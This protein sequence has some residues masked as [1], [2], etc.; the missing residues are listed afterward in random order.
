MM[1]MIVFET[2]AYDMRYSL[3]NNFHTRVHPG[4]GIFL[5]LFY[6][7]QCVLFTTLQISH[8]ETYLS[9]SCL[10]YALVTIITI[11]Q[12]P[13]HSFFSNS[14]LIF[15]HL[16]ALYLNFIFLL[17]IWIDSATA[18]IVLSFIMQPFI[19][20]LSMEMNKFL[21]N[22]KC[23][24]RSAKYAKVIE[25]EHYLR[26]GLLKHST[27]PKILQLFNKNVQYNMRFNNDKLIRVLQAYYCLEAL[28]DPELAYIKIG[29]CEFSGFNFL[30]NYQV[31]KCKEILGFLNRELSEG[32]KLFLFHNNFD[33]TKKIDFEI[34]LSLLSLFSKILNYPQDIHIIKS[35]LINNYQMIKTTKRKYKKL[36][37]EVPD[38]IVL[39]DIYS[40]FLFNILH[41]EDEGIEF[42]Q[43]RNRLLTELGGSKPKESM[44]KKDY[45]VLITSGSKGISG[46][47]VYA[48]DKMLEILGHNS[49]SIKECYLS[50]FIPMPFDY[51]H[52]NL[53]YNFPHQ[54]IS[55]K[56]IC[57]TFNFISVNEFLI[58]CEFETECIIYGEKPYFLSTFEM[59]NIKTRSVVL[60][61]STGFIMS[62][63]ENFLSM[64]SIVS[65]KEKN[66]EDI[67]H[68]P[69]FL[70]KPI[71]TPIKVKNN[72]LIG[73]INLIKL[74]NNT[75]FVVYFS[76]N[77][78]ELKNMMYKKSYTIR[79]PPMH[80]LSNQQ[81]LLTKKTTT[82]GFRSKTTYFEESKIE[83]KFKVS[84]TQSNS[85]V[86][87][88]V[89]IHK[90]ILALN[91]S[92]KSFK[93]MLYILCI[94]ILVV[95]TVTSIETYIMYS[96]GESLASL[97]HLKRFGELNYQLTKLAVIVRS[98]DLS[99]KN[100]ID[101]WYTSADL[102]ATVNDTTTIYKYFIDDQKSLKVCNSLKSESFIK[103]K[104]FTYFITNGDIYYS[105]ITNKTL[106]IQLS[107]L[108]NLI[109]TLLQTA[110][111]FASDSSG[112]SLR[113]E[114]SFLLIYNIMGSINKSLNSV[115]ELLNLCSKE[116]GF[117]LTFIE[118]Y[119]LIGG[120]GILGGLFVV[121]AVFVVYSEKH[122]RFLWDYLQD[123]VD[124][125]YSEIRNNVSERLSTVHLKDFSEE[126]ESKP[127]RIS[128]NNK[129]VTHSLRHLIRF[130]L[131]FALCI[132]I[133]V[134]QSKYFIEEIRVGLEYRPY[135]IA[136]FA[137]MKTSI[138]RIIF[139]TNEYAIR[140]SEYRLE[141]YYDFM[142]FDQLGKN[143][144]S[145]IEK[146]K[147]I[148]SI[149]RESNAKAL[150]TKAAED[151]LYNKY[152]G[153]TFSLHY[154]LHSATN[155]ISSESSLLRSTNFNLSSE[156]SAFNDF[157]N[158]LI[159]ATQIFTEMLDKTSYDIIISLLQ[160]LIYFT[161]SSNFFL[162]L[163]F[164]G[165]YLPYLKRET[166]ILIFLRKFS[167]F[168]PSENRKKMHDQ[169]QIKKN[170]TK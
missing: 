147:S 153:S 15:I 136:S 39:L 68:E 56:I 10:L 47:I 45:P 105:K 73:I 28:G 89:N 31:F 110:S 3:K 61:D 108:N 157:T 151:I 41:D 25:F 97:N 166:K 6:F 154:G 159:N 161:I 36:I 13:F 7:V 87:N 149:L 27:D 51:Q 93:V 144:D 8:Y 115:I 104:D 84:F 107:N 2:C 148:R 116:R 169:E 155:L 118:D 145:E 54:C 77:N 86:S 74:K 137:A 66:I 150:I 139:W 40:S 23:N 32:L 164:F 128:K 58:E 83:D 65:Y 146:L 78:Q 88:Y 131:L 133:M 19:L 69:H 100:L 18:G 44:T 111:L 72:T 63:S 12:M 112:Q 62:A 106:I 33:V 113:L 42:L 95:I 55:R 117:A 158:E 29:T 60:L 22:R 20:L 125:S 109:G 94:T 37:K 91:K 26:E 103:S 135:L 59:N 168:L 99:S 1:L 96:E 120:I 53:L 167:S 82:V 165:Y 30:I 134:V 121:L 122:V 38:S 16:D 152:P 143:I 102:I 79:E 160:N 43:R 162:I 80:M 140:D 64:F 132:G 48:N 49:E 124:R 76:S 127:V 35:Q 50:H 130:F 24:K 4:L 101:N 119:A 21:L 142:L 75:F 163:I 52:A 81:A 123:S 170:Y 90:E 14:I 71:Q 126:N 98:L 85:I 70:K 129:K 156:F 67:L 17:Q 5:K 114:S 141:N 46:K 34:C 57:N 11:Y 92:T 138:S 9:I